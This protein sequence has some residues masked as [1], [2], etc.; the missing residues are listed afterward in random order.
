LVDL[1]KFL[2]EFSF[3][4]CPSV[5]DIIGILVFMNTYKNFTI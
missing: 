5:V 2:V 4:S 3:L 1:Q